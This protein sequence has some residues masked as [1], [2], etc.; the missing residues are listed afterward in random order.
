[1]HSGNDCLRSNSRCSRQVADFFTLI[2]LVLAVSGSTYTAIASI[3]SWLGSH[4]R[5]W[6][7]SCTIC[8]TK[9]NEGGTAET[10]KN[11]N[12]DRKRFTRASTV[13]GWACAIPTLLFLAFSFWAA[14]HVSVRYFL[15]EDAVK[16]TT[17]V[18][19]VGI[20]YM[21]FIVAITI[22]DFL[23][24]LATFASYGVLSLMAERLQSGVR[25]VDELLAIEPDRRQK[26]DAPHITSTPPNPDTIPS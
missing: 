21:R 11:G 6:Q 22:A 16:I 15:A 9:I 13:W 14:G 1:M 17:I 24:I 25:Q 3:H 4:V 19:T 12:R 20:G 10:K 8:I 18:P 26:V 23:C 5:D 7:Q 2:G